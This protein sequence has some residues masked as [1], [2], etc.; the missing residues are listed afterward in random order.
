MFVSEDFDDHDQAYVSAWLETM[1]QPAGCIV[2]GF[3]VALS[4]I[5]PDGV[6]LTKV[7]HAGAGV[8]VVALGSIVQLETVRHHY[9]A[10][11]EC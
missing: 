10:P 7:F 3:V 6:H 2:D 9:E 5:D 11:E 4:W 1:E 8:T